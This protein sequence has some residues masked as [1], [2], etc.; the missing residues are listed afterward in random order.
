MLLC[1]LLTENEQTQQAETFAL[2]ALMCFHASRSDSR[3]TTEGEIVLLSLQNRS[4]WDFQLIAQGND[5]MN[6]AAFGNSISTYH[7]E[8]AIAFEHCIAESFGKTNWKRILELYNWLCKISPSPITELNRAV[9]I[10]QLEGA[11]AALT[12]VKN[13]SL[14]KKLESFYLYH[15]LLGEIYSRIKDPEKAKRFF[16]TAIKLTKSA[17]EKKLLKE[18]LAVL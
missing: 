1:R 6:K 14:K 18:K 12:A 11:R 17:T 15:S 4:K 5:Y 16:E 9:A 13:I 10:L 2:M 7:L 3:L 8:A